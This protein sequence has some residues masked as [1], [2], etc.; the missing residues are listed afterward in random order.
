M[1]AVVASITTDSPQHSQMAS[2]TVSVTVYRITSS[3]ARRR[4]W[5]GPRG[6]A[7]GD[8]GRHGRG[9]VLRRHRGRPEANGERAGL[10]PGT[11]R[12]APPGAAGRNGLDRSGVG[13]NLS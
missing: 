4:P 12:A 10:T 3:W 13:D 5:G 2:V 8:G 6:V 7:Q 1:I 11:S 9:R